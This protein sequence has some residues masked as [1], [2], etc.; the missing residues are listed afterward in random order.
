MND[1]QGPHD[2]VD[3]TDCFE[4]ISVFKSAKNFLFMII[5]ICL[6]LTQGVFWLKEVGYIEAAPD[7]EPEVA[8]LAFADTDP[9]PLPQ[10]E[11]EQNSDQAQ[12]DAAQDIL[13]DTP[14]QIE[15][16]A[17]QAADQ[18][19]GETASEDQPTQ[20]GEQVEQGDAAEETQDASEPSENR[21]SIIKPGK[22][23]IIAAVKIANFILVLASVTY[24]LLLLMSVKISLAG[25]MGGLTHIS[26]AF[27]CS[28]YF[29][30]FLLPWQTLLPGVVTGT[31]YAPAELMTGWQNVD[32]STGT[33]I[34]YYLRFVGMWVLVLILLLNAQ[35]RSARWSRTT[36]RRL[37]I[38]Q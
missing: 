33:Q 11:P 29:L 20:E 31:I 5:L 32:D 9:D 13:K 4:A 18:L 36:L 14:A 26:R 8:L 17:R 37:G 24:C 1:K 35:I 12:D 23:H 2:I 22:K 16:K 25:R 27:L 15:E 21:L 34:L 30:V 7:D 10:P 19:L 6:L 28:L 38:I 3:T